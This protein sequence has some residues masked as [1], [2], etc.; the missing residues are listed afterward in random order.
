MD[1]VILDGEVISQEELNVA[2]F[3]KNDT[4]HLKQCT[5]FGFGGIPLLTEN[6]ELIQMQ[7]NALQLPVPGVLKNRRELFRIIKRMLNKNKYYRSGLIYFQLFW[8]GDKVNSIITSKAFVTFEFPFQE[9][10]ILMDYSSQKKYSKNVLNRFSFF[11]RP[12]WEADTRWLKNTD[13]DSCLVLNENDRICDCTYSNIFLIKGNLLLTPEKGSGCYEDVLR[14]IIL[15]MAVQTGLQVTESE[16]IKASDLLQM[17]EIFTASEELGIHWVLG[18]EN[19]RF[20]HQHSI[21]IHK[22]LND[23]LKQKAH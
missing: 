3:I 21:S 1:F 10:G 6:I 20:V 5:W 11:N 12:L 14:H 23:F 8:N 17:D 2:P 13:L 4:F 22:N 16:Q 9:K 19:K 15:K 18:V 7:I